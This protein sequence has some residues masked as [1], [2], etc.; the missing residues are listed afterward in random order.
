MELRT[1][2]NAPLDATFGFN[3][4]FVWKATSFDRMQKVSHYCP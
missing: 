1:G 2:A 3:V 4:D